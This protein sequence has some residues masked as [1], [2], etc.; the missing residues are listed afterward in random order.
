VLITISDA[1]FLVFP[2]C[3]FG[4]TPT[5]LRLVRGRSLGVIGLNRTGFLGGCY[6]VL[7]THIRLREL[8]V[9]SSAG[10]PLG[11]PVPSTEGI[12]PGAAH[13]F[14]KVNRFELRTFIKLIIPV[15]YSV[16]NVSHHTATGI[17]RERERK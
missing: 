13:R 8:V 6:P 5:V 15:I 9:A 17:S 2:T 16:G 10:R 3:Q 7:A 1:T 14:Q 4:M 11:R 12:S